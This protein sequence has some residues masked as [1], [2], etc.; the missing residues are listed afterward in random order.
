MYLVA[1]MWVGD[2]EAD[3]FLAPHRPVSQAETLSGEQIP[4]PFWD[5]R[6]YCHRLVPTIISADPMDEVWLPVLRPAQ[7]PVSISS[8]RY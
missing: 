7:Q 4:S 6:P 8:P 5:G 3:S 1:G 2:I